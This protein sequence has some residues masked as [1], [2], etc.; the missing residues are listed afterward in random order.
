MSDL[1]Q[2]IR[3]LADAFD[4][5]DC[6]HLDRGWCYV[7]SS[8]AEHIK[9]GSC[10]TSEPK[11]LV[12]RLSEIQALCPTPIHLLRLYTGGYEREK[13]F[14]RQFAA[15]RLHAE[16]FS[17]IVIA[18]LPFSGCPDCDLCVIPG[19]IHPDD[20]ALLRGDR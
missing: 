2:L 6:E 13:A 5:L 9:I 15:H 17:S 12:G 3:P 10:R 1:E 18:E 11:R 19:G 16:W 14:H 4:E 20:L 7:I 8:S